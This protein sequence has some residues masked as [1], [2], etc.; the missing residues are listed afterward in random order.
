MEAKSADYI[1]PLQ[2]AIRRF[3]IAAGH[4]DDLEGCGG[5]HS[6]RGAKGGVYNPHGI[7]IDG[8]SPCKN[9]YQYFLSHELA[10]DDL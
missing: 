2:V 7:D 6:V 10:S 3:D 5:Q 1:N 4:V 9:R 8:A